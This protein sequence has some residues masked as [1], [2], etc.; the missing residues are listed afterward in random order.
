MVKRLEGQGPDLRVFLRARPSRRQVGVVFF[1]A[2]NQDR[3]AALH[4]HIAGIA[5]FLDES[6]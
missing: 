2:T 3:V 6:S 5:A 4:G 1:G